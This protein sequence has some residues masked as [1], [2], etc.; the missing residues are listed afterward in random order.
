VWPVFPTSGESRLVHLLM[1]YQGIT[2]DA[3]GSTPTT[4]VAWRL[5]LARDESAR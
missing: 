5:A 2:R 4:D 1:P 3:F